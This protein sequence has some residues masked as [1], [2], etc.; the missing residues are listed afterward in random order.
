MADKRSP[1]WTAQVIALLGTIPDPELACQLGR[2]HS[3][4]QL[5]RHRRGI[6]RFHYVPRWKS[7]EH[8]LLGTV[9]DAKPGGTAA[10]RCLGGEATSRSLGA[11][12]VPQGIGEKS[13]VLTARQA[14]GPV[15]PWFG[16]VGVVRVV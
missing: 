9:P 4:V 10:L 3:D 16:A 11:V 5:K 15:V 13:E 14:S 12:R 2:T 6:Q 8:A 1:P 7:E